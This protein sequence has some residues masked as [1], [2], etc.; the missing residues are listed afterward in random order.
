MIPTNL[1]SVITLHFSVT[2]E[3]HGPVAEPLA[4]A[5]PPTTTDFRSALGAVPKCVSVLGVRMED[6][7]WGA[8][9]DSFS[10][11]S[12]EP[13][14]V[15]VSLRNSSAALA[16][17]LD[18]RNFG[19]SVLSENQHDVAAAFAGPRQPQC[20]E[21][22]P[23][24]L[25]HGAPVLPDALAWFTCRLRDTHA[26]SDHTLVIGEATHAHSRPGQPLIRHESS[27]RTLG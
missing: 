6:A 1:A 8:T 25:S 10:S 20:G 23:L 17:L 19:V 18:T 21:E 12:L 13:P 26:V 4:P 15:M 11:V 22:G 2:A 9:I 24:E 5:P 7:R 3:E 27:Y 16:T 14:L